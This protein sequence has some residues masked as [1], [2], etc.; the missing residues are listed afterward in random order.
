MNNH[1]QASGI[2][3]NAYLSLAIYI[4]GILLF[5]HYSTQS[6]QTPYTGNSISNY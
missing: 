2:D 1:P 6:Q 5:A 3:V 4:L